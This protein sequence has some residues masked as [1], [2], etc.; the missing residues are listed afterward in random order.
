MITNY[1]GPIYG[2]RARYMQG[3]FFES[4]SS[5]MRQTLRVRA[6]CVQ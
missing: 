1:H 4:A 3:S 2:Y 5:A 6:E